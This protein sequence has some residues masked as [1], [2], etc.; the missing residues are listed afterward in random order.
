[1]AAPPKPGITGAIIYTRVSTEAQGENTSLAAQF[2]ACANKA[3]ELGL[4][5]LGIHEEIESGGLY[6]SRPKLQ[7]ALTA[8]EAGEASALIVYRLDR[9][10]RDVDALRDV[11]KRLARVGAQLIFADGFN[12]DGTATGTLMLTTLGAFAEHERAIIRERTTRGKLAVV[13]SGRQVTRTHPLGYRIISKSNVM[14]GTH[15]E[16]QVGTYEINEPEAEQVRAIFETYARLQTLRG[17]I[18]EITER[19]IVTRAGRPFGI[20]AISYIL[21]NEVY[22]GTAHYGRNRRHI[23]ESR[24]ARG[25]GIIYYTEQPRESWHRIEAPAIVG[26]ELFDTVQRL[27][28]S[29]TAQRS[30]RRSTSNLLSALMTCP[31]CGHV[32][33]YNPARNIPARI[34]CRHAKLQPGHTERACSFKDAPSEAVEFLVVDALCWLLESPDLIAAAEREYNS[35]RASEIAQNAAAAR[36][37]KLTRDIN[38]LAQQEARAV[39]FAMETGAESFA[40]AATQAAQKRAVLEAELNSLNESRPAP[41]VEL[42]DTKALI[43]VLRDGSRNDRRA[44]ITAIVEAIYPDSNEPRRKSVSMVLRAGEGPRYMLTH[45]LRLSVTY[46][47]TMLRRGKLKIEV[48]PVG[49]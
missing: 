42:G 46:R 5:V 21:K 3:R 40:A 16:D 7:A 12:P 39:R 32:L 6:L 23:D 20:N 24:L 2:A 43:G 15:R 48:K 14:R 35:T 1:M 26:R 34:A 19:G 9:A 13:A 44:V 36:A 41:V 37:A 18:R 38:R 30:G 33:Q 31:I 4:P 29:G 22:I 8:I 47:S 49:K 25:L 45:T 27:L 11:R 10:G 17:T 28:E